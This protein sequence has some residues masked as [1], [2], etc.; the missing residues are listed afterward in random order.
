MKFNKKE[1]WWC[2][3]TG[4]NNRSYIYWKPDQIVAGRFGTNAY[5]ERKKERKECFRGK[6]VEEEGL[7]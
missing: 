1:S 7:Q 3:V 4:K 2:W 6:I 5:K